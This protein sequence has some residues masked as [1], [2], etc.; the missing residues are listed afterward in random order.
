MIF[1]LGCGSGEITALIAERFPTAR[2]TGVDSSSAML[3]KARK[4]DGRLDWHE[5]DVAQ[6][7]P[8]EP[9]DLL[10]SNACLQW[11]PDHPTLFPHLLETL[12]P[13]GI[14]AAQMP[15]SWGQPSH[16]L[17]R[18]VL[19]TGGPGGTPIGQPS[20]RESL[21]RP[22]VL[23]ATDY[24]R[25]LAPVSTDLEIWKTEYFHFLQGDDPILEWV[26]G[27]GLRPILEGLSAVDLEIFLSRYQKELRRTY[28][29]LDDG[30]TLYPFSRLFLVARR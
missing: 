1:D 13:G 3:E 22:W 28:P 5:T 8:P 16:R 9:V 12:S 2:V 24:R 17:M 20:L 25:V 15:L 29:E 14:F 27:T 21:A 19:E 11:L 7:T 6:W 26:R 30:T 4:L 23:E 18:S 10:Y